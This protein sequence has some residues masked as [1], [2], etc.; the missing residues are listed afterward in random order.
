MTHSTMA[1]PSA[2][3]QWHTVS[4]HTRPLTLTILELTPLALTLSL[5]LSPPLPAPT[6]LPHTPT[7]H[8]VHSSHHTHAHSPLHSK[9]QQHQSRK[10]SQAQAGRQHR[11]SAPGDFTDD[12]DLFEE[13]DYSALVEG[14]TSFKDLLSH[15]VVVSVNGQPWSRIYAHVSEDDEDDFGDWEDEPSSA[16]ASQAQ[17]ITSGLGETENVNTAEDGME[18]GTMTRRRPRKARF[19]L[20]A[21][22]ARTEKEGSA[23]GSSAGPGTANGRRRKE[24][25]RE[26]MDRDRAVVVVYGL[27]PGKEYE[28]ELRVVGLFGQDDGDGVV[29]SSVLIPPSPTPNSG[30]H[31]RSRANSL[32]SRSRPR[33][34]SNSLSGSSAHPPFGSSPLSHTRSSDA[35]AT[36]D[37]L[38]PISHDTLSPESAIIPTPILNAVDTQA[39]QLRHLIATAHAEKDHLQAQIKEARRTSQRHEAALKAEIEAV[40]KAIEKAGS[41]DL[42]AKQKALA[43]QEQVKQ[44]WAGAEAAEKEMGDVESGLDTL[45]SRLEAMRIEVDAFRDEWKVAKEHEEEVRERDRKV[46][47]EEDKKLA[48]VVGKVE[49]L[50]AKRAKRDVETTELEKKLEDL[51]KQKEEA[52]KRN[53]EEKVAR[54]GTASYYAAGYGQTGQ[55]Q[56]IGQSHHDH[57]DLPYGGRSLSAHPSLNNLAGHYAAGPA[58]RP[59]GAPGGYQPRF[60]SAGARPSPSQPSP[61]HPN[62]FYSLSHPVP[63]TSTSPAFRPPKLAASNPAGSRSASGGASGIPIGGGSGVNAAAMPFHPSNFAQSPPSVAGQQNSSVSSPSAM[64]GGHDLSGHHT[65]ALMPPQL[66]H[67]IYLPNVRPRPTPNFH[68]PPSVVAEQQA[69]SAAALTPAIGAGGGSGSGSSASATASPIEPAFPPLG[70]KASGQTSVN[71]PS[72]P[73]LASIVTRAVLSPT[74]A[75]AQQAVSSSISGS[76]KQIQGQGTVTGS[77]ITVSPPHSSASPTPPLL[78]DHAHPQTATG[79]RTSGGRHLS[80]PPGGIGLGES[81]PQLSPTWGPLSPPSGGAG[82][83]REGTPPVPSWGSGKESPLSGIILKR[84][85]GSATPGT[86]GDGN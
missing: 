65:T 60:A 46:R 79:T 35:V 1:S 27:M 74:S 39:A 41:L 44:G 70:G 5:S 63:P 83:K 29:S 20:S 6:H 33:S 52:E 66:Q 55:N 34:R 49:K 68:P 16:S 64:A 73:S 26:R 28:V 45:E 67:R 17:A 61:T 81:F 56:S 22:E 71:V 42:R 75:L 62:A 7:Q 14:S 76:N 50:K 84:G 38:P 10:R 80:F 36:L 9:Q 58:Y 86:G 8:L 3:A 24:K 78:H 82:L 54:R 37:A 25:E 30:F 53:E 43:V 19:G 69:K 21:A 40:K 23:T 85:S 12:E 77:P 72:G 15:G 4:P 48:D 51:E 32:R 47:A 59:R 18:E 2:S 31:P 13:S 57:H 11:R